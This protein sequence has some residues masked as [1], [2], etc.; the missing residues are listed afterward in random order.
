MMG[1][2]RSSSIS[3]GS[4]GAA[5]CFTSGGVHPQ[6]PGAVHHPHKAAAQQT[7][8]TRRCCGPV[9]WLSVGSPQ[10]LPRV[11]GVLTPVHSRGDA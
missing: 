2:S 8:S 7:L 9:V 4:A 6:R 1:A 5:A 3:A 10:G 11:R